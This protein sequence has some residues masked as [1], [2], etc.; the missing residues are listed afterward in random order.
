MRVIVIGGSGFVGTALVPELLSHGCEVVLINRG[1]RPVDHV[2]NLVADRNDPDALSDAAR[3]VGEADAVIDTCAYTGRQTEIAFDRFAGRVRRWVHLS[4]A[5]VYVDPAR[6]PAR[7]EDAIGGAEAWGQY[8]RDKSAADAL[9][10]RQDAPGLCILRPPYLYGPRN[11]IDRETF[12]WS[13]LLRGRRVV[14]PSNGATPLQFLHVADLARALSKATL[15]GFPEKVY[16][17]AGGPSTTAEEWVRLLARLI[18]VQEDRAF[19]NAG[20][21]AGTLQARQYF[22]FRDFP[23]SVN[24]AKI[25]AA[26]WTPSFDLESG[27]RQTLASLDLSELSQRAIDTQ[28]EDVVL[29][30]LEAGP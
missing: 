2:E 23:C 5:A 10:L 26:G 27:F 25:R 15:V 12:V 20:S 16:N 14:L 4:S 21:A 9:L 22:P 29:E 28:W 6:R 3:R 7:E 17:V 1:S 8:G 24:D 30:R 11:D 18:G 19:T 13:R